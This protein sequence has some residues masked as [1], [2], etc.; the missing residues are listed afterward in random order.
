MV[1]WLWCKFFIFFLSDFLFPLIYSVICFL[2]K[3]GKN[4]KQFCLFSQSNN[5][6]YGF[7]RIL[8]FSLCNSLT[9]TFQ[10]YQ[11]EK[12]GREKK[13]NFRMQ[14]T[15]IGICP[16]GKDELGLLPTQ[17]FK[18]GRCGFRYWITPWYC[19]IGRAV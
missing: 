1:D 10:N 13:V 7:T 2:A 15:A 19:D 18:T 9:E 5:K 6:V 11:S 8:G 4:I 17:C 12:K 14:R 3:Y 16:G